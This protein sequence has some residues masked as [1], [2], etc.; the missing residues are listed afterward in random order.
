MLVLPSYRLADGGTR[1]LQNSL[2]TNCMASPP[3]SNIH[4]H[5]C[6]NIKSHTVSKFPSK[7]WQITV[8][9]NEI[10]TVWPSMVLTTTKISHCDCCYVNRIYNYT[11]CKYKVC[12]CVYVCV[13]GSPVF[14]HTVQLHIILLSKY[15]SFFSTYIICQYSHGTVFKL[16]CSVTI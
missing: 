16:R 15:Y 7:L 14:M 13:S 11:E 5:H 2:P 1:F 4:G 12:V 10:N 9:H 3:T 6:E 8:Y